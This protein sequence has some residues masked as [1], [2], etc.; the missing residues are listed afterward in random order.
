MTEQRRR[1]RTVVTNHQVY[2]AIVDLTTSNP[3]RTATRQTIAQELGVGYALVDEHV[4]KLLAKGVVRRLL[5]GVFEP[6]EVYADKVIGV[7]ALPDGRVKLEVDDVVLN[8]TRRDVKN[9]LYCLG[10]FAINYS[11]MDAGPKL[12]GLKRTK[13]IEP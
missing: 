10:G 6:T 5:P 4:D 7:M 8:L 9:I 13:E 2:Q 3:S 12:A 11:R 1:G